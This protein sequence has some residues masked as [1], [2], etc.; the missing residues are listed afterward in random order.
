MIT[1]EPLSPPFRVFVLDDHK[2]VAEML[3]HRLASNNH[4][5][6]V[7]IANKGSA[8]IHFAQSQRIDIALLDM[9]LDD[10][11]GIHIARELLKSDP[12]VRVVGL[13]AHVDD[14]YPLSLLEAGGRGFISKRSSTK[15]IIDSIHRVARGDMAISAEVAFHLARQTQG[16]GPVNKVRG[17]SPKETQVLKLLARGYSVGEV[18]ERLQIGSKTVQSHRNS[19]KKKLRVKT[20]VEMCLA[21]LRSRIVAIHDGK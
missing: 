8:V 20:D 7:G 19:V 21:A 16:A 6:V 12:R 14:H 2:F 18:A 9:E 15:E 5:N 11:D 1:T 10:D 3:T 13:S 4:I 17:L